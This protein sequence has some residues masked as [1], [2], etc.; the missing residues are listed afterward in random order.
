MAKGPNPNPR[1]EDPKDVRA[2]QG[3]VDDAFTSRILLSVA[4]AQRNTQTLVLSLVAVVVLV[5][6]SI[7][8]F[9]QRAGTYAEAAIQLEQV[10]SVAATADAG[11]AVAELE[12]YLARFGNTPYGIEARLVLGEIHLGEGN[13]EAA[14]EALRPVAPSFRDPL[15]LQATFLLAVAYESGERWSDAI[16]VYRDLADRAEMTFQRREAKEGLARAHLANGDTASAAD[17]Y[18]ALVAEF[19]AEEDATARGYFEMRLHELGRR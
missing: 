13:V 17:A 7:W 4:W 1:K 19:S 10:Q 18:R 2:P 16:G 9:G 3:T 15:R 8:F 6:G 14:I 5:V 11:E 12:R